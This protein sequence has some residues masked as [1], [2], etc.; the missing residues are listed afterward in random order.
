MAARITVAR[1]SSREV[2]DDRRKERLKWKGKED[3]LTRK[4]EERER[5]LGQT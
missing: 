5:R 2:K 4:G 3:R 1:G